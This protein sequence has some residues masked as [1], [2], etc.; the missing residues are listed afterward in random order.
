MN[1]LDRLVLF[2]VVA[3]ILILLLVGVYHKLHANSP[4]PLFAVRGII[5]GLEIPAHKLVH[6]V[7]ADTCATLNGVLEMEV[8]DTTI[9]GQEMKQM[10]WTCWR[11]I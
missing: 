5:E 10:A 7:L 6:D 11:G 3:F 8:S 1:F 9:N 2:T 4:L